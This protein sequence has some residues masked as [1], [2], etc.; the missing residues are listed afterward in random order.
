[1]SSYVEYGVDGEIIGVP[2]WSSLEFS[3]VTI[4][5]EA[6]KAGKIASRSVLNY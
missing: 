2:T 4:Y 1:M 6:V 3:L 5:I